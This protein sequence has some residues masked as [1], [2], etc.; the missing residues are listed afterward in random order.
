M[1]LFQKFQCLL[2]LPVYQQRL[3]IRIRECTYGWVSL[4][5]LA[6]DLGSRSFFSDATM[7]MKQSVTAEPANVNSPEIK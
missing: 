6:I 1:L 7:V 5:S 2:G 3:C 4:N